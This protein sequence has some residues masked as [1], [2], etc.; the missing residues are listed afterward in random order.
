MATP[1][2]TSASSAATQ[3]VASNT[4][5][6]KIEIGKPAQLKVIA[7]G[8]TVYDGHVDA[9]NVMRFDAQDALEITSSDSSA[10]L[11][12]LNGQTVPPM[13]L[14]GQSGIVTL[15][16]KDLKPAAGVPH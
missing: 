11:L 8:R 15:T 5:D 13:G 9:G 14:P 16:R 12:E 2:S 4:L 10:L 7:D 3:P 1:A 6:L